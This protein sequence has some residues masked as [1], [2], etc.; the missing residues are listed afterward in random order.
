MRGVCF[1]TNIGLD[2]IMITM[3]AN[4]QGRRNNNVII[5]VVMRCIMKMMGKVV[6]TVCRRAWFLNYENPYGLESIPQRLE[7]ARQ[8]PCRR[9]SSSW[10][11]ECPDPRVAT[12]LSIKNP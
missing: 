1:K 2:A 12:R 11:R 5:V 4:Q 6:G 8:Q 3:M 7:N 10:A 9:V